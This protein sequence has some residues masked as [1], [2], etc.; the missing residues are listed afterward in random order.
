MPIRRT[1]LL[2]PALVTTAGLA[3]A[4]CGGGGGGNEADYV[5]T[6]EGACKDIVTATSDFQ[7]SASGLATT[8]TSD[9]DKAVSTLKTSATKL[10]DTFGDSIRTLA[11]ADAPSKWSD[12]QDSVKNGADDA[13]KGIDQIKQEISKISSI[14]DFASLGSKF[15]KIDLGNTKDLPNDLRDKVPSCKSFG[16][17]SSS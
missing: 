7:K 12:F 2:L 11:D 13:Q 17:G 5:K 1:R 10:F 9:P 14:Q 16:S 6:Y 8:A 3:V 4:G 15:D